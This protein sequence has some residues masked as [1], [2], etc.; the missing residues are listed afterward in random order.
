[1]RAWLSGTSSRPDPPWCC[2]NAVQ[3]KSLSLADEPMESQ[4][5][6][7]TRCISWENVNAWYILQINH[8]PSWTGHDV[9]AVLR[10][11]PQTASRAGRQRTQ[12]FGEHSHRT[13]DIPLENRL[14]KIHE[15]WLR[16]LC[17]GP[18]ASLLFF[19]MY[20]ESGMRRLSDF[21]RCGKRQAAP[22]ASQVT[23][24]PSP[25]QTHLLPG[26]NK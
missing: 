3:V 4:K 20:G 21:A 15:A 18:F 7:P 9:S 2:N 8:W 13:A 22:G 5:Q 19:C 23:G 24:R 6:R 1:M 14:N 12:F 25:N 10:T 16:R 26:L 17:V 11:N